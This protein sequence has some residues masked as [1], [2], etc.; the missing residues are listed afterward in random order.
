MSSN[1]IIVTA[2]SPPTVAS[3]VAEYRVHGV[4]AVVVY[5]DTVNRMHAGHYGNTVAL[6]D[7]AKVYPLTDRILMEHVLQ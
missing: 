1:I 2:S 6:A 3:L 7:I 4:H 5:A